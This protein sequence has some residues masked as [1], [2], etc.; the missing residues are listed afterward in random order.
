[1][2]SYLVTHGFW[3]IVNERYKKP[4]SVLNNKEEETEASIEKEKN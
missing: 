1:M 3:R 2:M 4:I